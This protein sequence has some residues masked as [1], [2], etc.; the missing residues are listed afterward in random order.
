[1][2]YDLDDPNKYYLLTIRDDNSQRKINFETYDKLQIIYNNESNKYVAN[3]NIKNF[4]IH[5]INGT[6]YFE[7]FSNDCAFERTKIVNELSKVFFDAEK[8]EIKK[9]TSLSDKTGKSTYEY[10]SFEFSSGDYAMVNCYNW[11]E[12]YGYPDNLKVQLL[13]NDVNQWITGN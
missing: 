11:S 10:V 3:K 7:N 4:V 13:T 1:M 8:S 12:E 5:S 9:N 6:L 2:F